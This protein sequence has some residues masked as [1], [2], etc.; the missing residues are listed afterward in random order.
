MDNVP[1]SLA[2]KNGV[3]KQLHDVSAEIGGTALDILGLASAHQARASD[4]RLGIIRGDSV[5]LNS[6]LVKANAAK[7][8]SSS[9]GV[10][11]SIQLERA[12]KK[13]DA[14]L[15][16]NVR[17]DASLFQLRDTMKPKGKRTNAARTMSEV[18][19]SHM[20]VRHSTHE[21]LVFL[22]DISSSY[23]GS[24]RRRDANSRS[25]ATSTVKSTAAL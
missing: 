20:F 11:H 21:L 23:L 2:S 12:M 14:K 16:T 13:K 8:A 22:Q 15:K 18:R 3:V 4:P 7:K 5:N 17:I 1:Q 6:N 24:L 19:C 10:G 25:M 9:L